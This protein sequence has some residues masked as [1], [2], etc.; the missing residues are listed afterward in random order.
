VVHPQVPPGFIDQLS[1]CIPNLKKL[2]LTTGSADVVG[3]MLKHFKNLEHLTVKCDFYILDEPQIIKL[4][5]KVLLKLRHLDMT[6]N[7]YFTT[8]HARKF[9]NN[10]CNL[11]YLKIENA[12]N[13]SNRS[14]KILLRGLKNLKEI[15]LIRSCDRLSMNVLNYLKIYGKNLEKVSMDVEF[16][17]EKVKEV[18]ADLNGLQF[19]GGDFNIVI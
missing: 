7:D 18:L 4:D 6:F 15:H 19:S 12:L 14:V 10:F 1:K 11:E 2:T 8:K 17:F 9:V 3:D 5:E 13:I 16:D